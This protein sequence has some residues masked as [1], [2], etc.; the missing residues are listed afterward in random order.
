ATADANNLYTNA[1]GSAPDAVL[2]L[3]GSRLY[4]V[5]FNGGTNGLGTVFGIGTNGSGFSVLKTFSTN[6]GA[7]PTAGLVVSG[8]TLY[9][10]TSGN[11]ANGGTVFKVNTDGSGFTVLKSFGGPNYGDGINPIGGLVLS[12]A[13]LFGTTYQWGYGVGT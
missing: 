11:G 3:A 10:T 5:T 13:T 8:N 4:G 6:D 7:Y 9:G 12:N 2:A 1:D